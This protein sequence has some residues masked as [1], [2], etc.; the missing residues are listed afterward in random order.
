MPRGVY[1]RG[2]KG[3]L[4]TESC[5]CNI[6]LARAWKAETQSLAVGDAVKAATPEKPLIIDDHSSERE[7]IAKWLAWR[8]KEPKISMTEASRRLGLQPSTL[9]RYVGRAEKAGWL[10]VQ[11]P[12]ER[13]EKVIIPKTLDNIEYFLAKRDRVVTV[14]TAKNTVYRQFQEA[15]GISNAP[16]TVL[17]LRIEAA[18]QDAPIISSSKVVGT[19]R[20]VEGV[21]Q[22]DPP[23]D[24]E[25]EK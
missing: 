22:L 9:R 21:V 15:K 7:A 24:E 2:S 10:Q 12:I 18:P 11:D 16:K 19:P 4:H 8:V 17:A 3:Q 25:K 14:E 1:K 6:C 13:I 23:K 5:Q 20:F